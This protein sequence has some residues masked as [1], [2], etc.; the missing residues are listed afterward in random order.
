MEKWSGKAEKKSGPQFTRTLQ[1]PL[2]NGAPVKTKHR[3]HQLINALTVVATHARLAHTAKGCIQV[4]EL[5]Q[6]VIHH[7]AARRDLLRQPVVT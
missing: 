5:V 6:A 7:A 4:G 3:L 1:P 2:S